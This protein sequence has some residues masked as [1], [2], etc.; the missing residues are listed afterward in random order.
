MEIK[1]IWGG[2][3]LILYGF[4]FFGVMIC[5][6]EEKLF[7]VLIEIECKFCL[8]CINMCVNWIVFLFVIGRY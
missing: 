1:I 8:N 2:D 7:L 5:F 3:G 6:M 4:F